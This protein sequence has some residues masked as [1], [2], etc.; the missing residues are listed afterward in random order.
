[1]GA[2]IGN[3]TTISNATG[4]SCSGAHNNDG[5]D[6]VL[7]VSSDTS[8]SVSEATYD[9]EA[10]TQAAYQNNG[11][12]KTWVFVKINAAEGS[13]TAEVVFSGSSTHHRVRAFSIKNGG[14]G[15]GNTGTD[16]T[17]ETSM[18]VTINTAAGSILIGNACID[19]TESDIS[20]SSGVTESDDVAISATTNK[21]WS[22]WI[23]GTG[24]NVTLGC[25]WT[26]NESSSLAVV[27]ILPAPGF[28]G[29]KIFGGA[30]IEKVK[31]ILKRP[32]REQF[33]LEAPAG[34]LRKG[35][36]LLIPQ[37]IQEGKT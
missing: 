28:G 3:V 32:V 34:W 12:R 17:A 31:D 36:G 6:V 30:F 29:S 10:M 7:V 2:E 26:G 14:V 4:S 35:N 16:T 20:P 11:G 27:E 23:P 9:E 37:G 13:N 1:M 18:A 33:P 8:N 21:A 25:S 22:G 19:N 24:E 15:V 5:D